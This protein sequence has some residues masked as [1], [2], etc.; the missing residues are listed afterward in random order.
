MAG[1]LNLVK[2]FAF[3]TAL[4]TTLSFNAF[5]QD[6]LSFEEREFL[7]NKESLKV[8]VLE[9]DWLPYWG[10]LASKE[11]IN[12]EYAESML[13]DL[14]V[15]AEYVPY[16]S[17]NTLFDGLESG[18]IDLTVGFVATQKRAQRFLY[19]QPIFNTLRLIWL[20]D[21]SL[22]DK[23]LDELKWVCVKDSS[24]CDQVH[25]LGFKHVHAVKNNLM[26]TASLNSG[27]A[28]AAVVGLSTL[29]SY[30]FKNPNGE[31]VGKVV[32][33]RSL[34]PG[35]VTVFTGKNSPKLMS[36]IDKYI[37]HSKES[38]HSRLHIEANINILHNELMLDILKQQQ[39]HKTVRYT[40]QDNVYPLSYLDRETGELKGYVHDLLKL[41]EQKSM[42]K[43]EYVPTNGRDVDL[44]LQE[45]M[46]DL[47]PARNISLTDKKRFITTRTLGFLQYG[48]IES[49]NERAK[50]SVAILDRSGN[51]YPHFLE[52]PEYEFAAVY[53]EFDCLMKAFEDGDISHAFVNQSLIDNHYYGGQGVKFKPATPPNDMQLK[54]KLGMELRKDSEFLRRVL[55][56]VLKITTDAELKQLMDRHNKVTVQYGVDKEIVVIWALVGVCVL[57]VAVLIYILRTG[58][59]TR[60]I[61]RKEYETKV[62]QRQNRWLSSVLD[63]IPNKILISDDNHQQILANKPY[64]S[65]LQRCNTDSNITDEQRELVLKLTK[66]TDY[67]VPDE[68]VT[69]LC[70]LGKKHYR[71]RR[72]SLLHPEEGTRFHMTV[73][74]DITELKKK[75]CALKA[76]NLKAMQ[77]IEAREHFLAV[78][79]HELRTPIAAMLGLM[80]LLEQDLDRPESKE[81]LKSAMLSAER[82]QLHVNDILDFSKVDANQL[83]LDVHSGNVYEELG[84]SLRSFEKAVEQK[85]LAFE[86]NWQPTPYALVNL[87]WLRVNQIINN[88]LSNAV[89][90][91]DKGKISV[92]IH[93]RANELV[94]SVQD[95]GC[96][97]SKAQL[98]ALFQPFV[99]GDKSISRRF[100]G[101]GLG[102]SIVKK[103]VDIMTGTIEVNSKQGKGT[104]V[105]VRLP[106][107][108]QPLDLTGM[109]PIY[110]EDKQIQRWLNTWQVTLDEFELKHH[111]IEPEPHYSNVYPDLIQQKLNTS[112][113]MPNHWTQPTACQWQGRVLVVDDDAI[114]RLLFKRQFEK[115]GV[116]CQLA[117]SGSEAIEL[118]KQAQD[119]D[120]FAPISLII[121]DCHM[122]DMDGYQLTQ[123]LKASSE[124]SS[125]PVV[126]CT[127]ENSRNV[128]EKAEQNG[129]ES[130]L[131]KPYNLDDLKALCEQYLAMSFSSE[132]QSD[133]L[134]A[135]HHEEKAEMAY[136]VCEAL[137]NDIALI[138]SGEESLKSVAHRIKGS[139]AALNLTQ[140]KHSAQQ[141]EA[142]IGT[143]QEQ[144]ARTALLN[145]LETIIAT[146]K[147]WLDLSE[148]N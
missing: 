5:A 106:M 54:I 38:K 66:D 118:L 39:G 27:A 30:G 61:K 91:T 146:T 53:R 113:T 48:F 96:G 138:H 59:L 110:T 127:A 37:K 55:N 90:F 11:G 84:S 87:D 41:M 62:R 132:T 13:H 104:E 9:G 103:L 79:S 63:H 70:S 2:L 89:K 144:Q 74:D 49:L 85:A 42:I 72:Q 141:C 76:S 7:N 82:L 10:D 44:M 134:D 33:N 139:A 109:G 120:A 81:L 93:V 107:T 65:M 12:I 111:V 50:K 148:N 130:V 34:K 101:T 31:L 15:G 136:V 69:T 60:K 92:N 78:I 24:A 23:P 114:N 115:L 86:V 28:D 18:E 1:N 98:D 71:V 57:L 46:V 116:C 123:K 147:Q 145:E 102:M 128:I 94:F 26:M 47:L 58:H 100:G 135:Y 20:R 126:G 68:I 99:Q 143:E 51:F 131:F 95:S 108:S 36:I 43:F 129:M 140:L 73:F 45:K 52:H 29:S 8:G 3:I 125:L 121:S 88:L 14:H 40:I 32:Y 75:E 119:D 35:E 22:A 137:S 6:F 56:T 4:L 83:Q 142:L 77:A 21:D 97:M 133:W 122:P 105:T 80:E 117:A 112:S 25:A 67:P 19:S 16:K 64:L 124:F 17:L